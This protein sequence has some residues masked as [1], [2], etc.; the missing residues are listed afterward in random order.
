M[1][2]DT[3]MLKPENPVEKKPRLGDSGNEP[4]ALPIQEFEVEAA[5]TC[6]ITKWGD[7]DQLK[8]KE[9]KLWQYCFLVQTMEEEDLNKLEVF[10]RSYIVP[11]R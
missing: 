3:H 11:H 7:E 6:D 2:S 10:T 8:L 4:I 9:A 1:E 5:P